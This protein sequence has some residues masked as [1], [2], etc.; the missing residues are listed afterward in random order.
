M[1]RK[2]DAVPESA[3][4]LVG[5]LE[6]LIPMAG[7]IDKHEESQRI[8]REITKLMKETM[9]AENKL[10]NPAFV[11]RAPADV[12]EKERSRLSELKTTLEKL[13]QQLE[14]ISAMP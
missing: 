7:L 2:N 10:S 6:I 13:Q 1:V 11:D 9:S 3:T 4:A 14:K 12:V 8:N 5:N